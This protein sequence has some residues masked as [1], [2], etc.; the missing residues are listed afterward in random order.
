MSALA[1]LFNRFGSK[2][3][4][5]PAPSW[6]PVDPNGSTWAELL[7]TTPTIIHTLPSVWFPLGAASAVGPLLKRRRVHFLI[8]LS[9]T[10]E[11]PGSSEALAKRAASYLTDHP[12]HILAFLCNTDRETELMRA[13]GCLAITINHNCLIDDAKFRPMPEIEP[14]YDAVYN[15]RLSPDKRNE[16][17]CE[18][19]KLALLYFYFG[20]ENS[21]AEFHAI[22]ARLVGLMPNARFVNELTADGCRWLPGEEINRVLAQSRVGLCLSKAEG[23][24]RASIEYLFAGLSVVSTPSLGGRDRFFDDEFCIICQPDPRSVREAVEALIARNVPRDYVRSKTLARVDLERRRY[25]DFVQ[26]LIER[27]RGNLR[28]EDR[29][30]E[31]TRG[32]TILHYRSMT[33]F[34]ETV[35][36]LVLGTKLPRLGWPLTGRVIRQG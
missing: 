17:A 30:W 1:R 2:A 28:F 3:R 26:E 33:E 34:S 8:M 11:P 35:S 25:I 5:R 23:A 22:H 9:W 27:A 15:A 31:L 36:R 6:T 21:P 4:Q 19:D 16:L 20:F 18:V 12:K 29:F 7:S 10:V 24:M 14:V 13:A 32:Q